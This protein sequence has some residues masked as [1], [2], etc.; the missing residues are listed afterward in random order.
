[1]VAKGAEQRVV[2]PLIG[3]LEQRIFSE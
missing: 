2:G 1:M 3:V